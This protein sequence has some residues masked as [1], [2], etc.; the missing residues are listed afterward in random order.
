MTGVVSP[1]AFAIGLAHGLGPP[2]PA[3]GVTAL[4]VTASGVA[5]MARP[6]SANRVWHLLP[7]RPGRAPSWLTDAS[8]LRGG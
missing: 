2:V 4:T 3:L 1:G 5:A 8:L 7:P 6:T